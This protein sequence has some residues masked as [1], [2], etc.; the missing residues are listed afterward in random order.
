ML[1]LLLVEDS[2]SDAEL[3]ENQIREE[4]IKFRLTRVDSKEEFHAAM[5]REKWDL[6]LT[7]FSLP[8][9]NAMD[10]LAIVRTHDPE[11]PVIL[12]TGTKPEGFGP[13]FIKKGQRITF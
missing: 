10:V 7:D 12:V 8:S 9:F 2:E 11:V 1:R 13:D 6:I 5:V 4:R 3:I